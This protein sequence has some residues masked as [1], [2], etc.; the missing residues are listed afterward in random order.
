MTP[1][2]DS[3]ARLG[4]VLYIPPPRLVQRA[5]T[6]SSTIRMTFSGPRRSVDTRRTGIRRVASADFGGSNSARSL[7]RT[8]SAIRATPSPVAQRH[9]DA[10]STQCGLSATRRSLRVDQF[11]L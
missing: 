6:D 9:V 11:A 2:D 8:E 7:A 5:P 3:F 4:V 10:T 1:R